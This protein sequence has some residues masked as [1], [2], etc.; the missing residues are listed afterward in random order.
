VYYCSIRTVHIYIWVVSNITLDWSV[1]SPIS[2]S[3]LPRS[4][5]KRP[6]R[7]RFENKINVQSIAF[8]VSFFESQNSI[9]YL[10]LDV[11]LAT[12]RWKDTN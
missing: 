5:G 9:Y 10:V 4:V 12:F 8:G 6:I 1:I 2:M 11:S 7:L 3:L